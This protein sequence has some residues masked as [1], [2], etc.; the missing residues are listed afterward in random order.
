MAF[1]SPRSTKVCAMLGALAIQI[2]CLP[3]ANAQSSQVTVVNSAT[4]PVPVSGTVNVNPA[5]QITNPYQVERSIGD[6]STCAPQCTINFTAVPDGKRLVITNVSSQ[7]GTNQE[8]LTI[9]GNGNSFF[10]P[11][12]YPNASY[13]AA[14][15]T[16]YFEAGSTPSVRFF[17]PDATQHT[18]LIVTLVGYLVPVQ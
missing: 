14:P 10:V 16:I 15:V 6:S 7:I 2:F 13:L 17:V 18:S 1:I 9:E 12:A 11:K 5:P 4:D 8:V 3:S